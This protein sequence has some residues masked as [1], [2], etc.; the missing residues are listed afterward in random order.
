MSILYLIS[1]LFTPWYEKTVHH[2]IAHALFC[3]ADV[4]WLAVISKILGWW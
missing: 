4:L 3:I 2:N 1:L